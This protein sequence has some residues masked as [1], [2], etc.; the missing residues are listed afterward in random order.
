M[1]Y[2]TQLLSQLVPSLVGMALTGLVG[3]LGGK[4]EGARKEREEARAKETEERDQTRAM[5]RLLMDYRL[6]D[7]FDTYV[8]RGEGI[9][10][11]D[12][13]EIEVVYGYYHDALGGNGE[14]TRM[15]NELMA[16]K[17]S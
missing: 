12:K 16:L 2:V 3:W 9:S 15:Y 1:D 13:H 11:A 14:G 17:T 5:L 4:I 8:V 10:I 6:R 7:M